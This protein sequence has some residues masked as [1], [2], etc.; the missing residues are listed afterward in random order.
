MALGDEM[1]GEENNR[2]ND[3]PITSLPHPPQEIAFFDT[4]PPLLP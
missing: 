3:R 1:A 4:L 2:S